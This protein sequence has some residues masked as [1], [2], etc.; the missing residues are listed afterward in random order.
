MLDNRNSI[1]IDRARPTICRASEVCRRFRY[2]WGEIGRENRRN[3]LG[4]TPIAY[5]ESLTLALDVS[6]CPLH[7]VLATIDF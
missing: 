3:C 7:C 2:F 4:G 6:Y 1:C 5:L